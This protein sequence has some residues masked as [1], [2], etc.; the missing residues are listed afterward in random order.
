VAVDGV[1]LALVDVN[2]E[3]TVD[4]LCPCLSCA[5]SCQCLELSGITP[6][7]GVDD[8]N[9]VE[10]VGGLVGAISVNKSTA[11]RPKSITPVSPLLTCM[12]S[13]ISWHRQKS[14][15]S[16][17]SFPNFHYNH[18]LP[19]C[20]GLVSDTANY[21]ANKSATSWQL[22]HLRGSYGETCL[23]DFGQYTADVFANL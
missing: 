11:L 7:T 16:V 8:V 4:V 15:V 6:R 22:P 2:V 19:T 21:L 20:D 12:K 18:L 10:V 23:M 17:M 3:G 5:S 9:G 13:I 1:E 14:I